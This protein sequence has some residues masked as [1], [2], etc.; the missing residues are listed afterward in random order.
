MLGHVRIVATFSGWRANTGNP[1]ARRAHSGLEILSLIVIVIAG[2]GRKRKEDLIA[3]RTGGSQ[4]VT[5][6]SVRSNPEF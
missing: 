3:P 4:R 1:T 2:L 5:L 6:A